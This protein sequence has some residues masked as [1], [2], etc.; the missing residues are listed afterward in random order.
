MQFG[1]MADVAI[2]KDGKAA[3][4]RVAAAHIVCVCVVGAAGKVLVLHTCRNTRGN[5]IEMMTSTTTNTNIFKFLMVV[6]L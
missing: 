2:E 3:G 1:S 6:M 4:G 5:S